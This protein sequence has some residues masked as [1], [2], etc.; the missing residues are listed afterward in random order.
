MHP[1]VVGSQIKQGRR[2][3]IEAS[4]EGDVDIVAT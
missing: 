2:E 4:E 1:R 3:I